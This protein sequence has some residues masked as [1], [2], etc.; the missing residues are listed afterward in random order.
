MK[1][2]FNINSNYNF[3]GHDAGK[4]K[5][6]YMQ[7]RDNSVSSDMKKIAKQD[8]FE[9]KF[10]PIK[11]FDDL[12][13]FGG[14]KWLQDVKAFIERNDKKFLLVD[15]FSCPEAEKSKDF[16]KN[17]KIESGQNFLTGGNYF[18]G[19]KQN[20]EKWLLIGKTNN[21]FDFA[22]KSNDEIS[23]IYDVKKENIHYITS[24]RYHL[25]MTIRPIGY[26]YV[27]V[28][29]LKKVEENI[30][31]IKPQSEAEKIPK[32]FSNNAKREQE[33]LKTK[34]QIRELEKAGFVPI[35]IAGIYGSYQYDEES[36]NFMNA[37]VN[38]HDDNSISYITNSTECDNET[39][40]KLQNMFEKDLQSALK[41][42]QM[43]RKKKN[44][45]LSKLPKPPILKDTFFVG[46]KKDDAENEM[47]YEDFGIHCLCLEEMENE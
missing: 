6:L 46:G 18:I 23:K 43:Q 29:D 47:M 25:D 11:S 22:N 32:M 4:I 28:N 30:K 26:P 15:R 40:S 42:A 39:L 27:L 34:I 24:P 9:L 37:I 41:N 1:V 36:L 45:P 21:I 33:I 38:K 12:N 31:K 5:C 16:Y 3:K 44:I 7:D 13:I 10:E 14:V 19:K 35:P 2:N 17:V 8:G 20:G